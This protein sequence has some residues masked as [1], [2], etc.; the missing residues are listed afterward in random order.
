VTVDHLV[1][2]RDVSSF[3]APH[4]DEGLKVV[5]RFSYDVFH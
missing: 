2:E 4:A 5:E 3:D 1:R